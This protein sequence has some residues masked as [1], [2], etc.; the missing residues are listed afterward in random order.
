VARAV[1]RA[2]GPQAD[3]WSRRFYDAFS[4]WQL[5]PDEV[6]V[7]AA[8]TAVPLPRTDVLRVSVNARAFAGPHGAGAFEGLAEAGAL[9]VRL[10]DDARQV[11]DSPPGNFHVCLMG[12]AQALSVLGL[13]YDS[14]AGRATAAAM[15]AVVARGVRLGVE[16]TGLARCHTAIEPQPRLALLANA[17][18]DALEPLPG[19]RASAE[20]QRHMR[21]AVQP[22]IDQP[23]DYP[24]PAAPVPAAAPQA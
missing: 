18:T 4:R 10:L 7:R 12:I 21:L 9:A 17:T 5:L 11:M 13:A 24:Y 2:E 8:G 6:L 15:A 20:A 3:A 23:I 16:E 22:W 14:D 19:E 1:A